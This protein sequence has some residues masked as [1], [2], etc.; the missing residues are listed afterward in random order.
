[1]DNKLYLRRLTSSLYVN[2]HNSLRYTKDGKHLYKKKEL[3]IAT[4]LLLIAL[5]KFLICTYIIDT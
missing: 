5:I 4:K 2:Y 3:K 1:M